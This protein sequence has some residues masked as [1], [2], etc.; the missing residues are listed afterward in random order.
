MSKLIS[1]TG[2]IFLA[3][4][5]LGFE[6]SD[7]SNLHPD[8]GEILSF[9]YTNFDAGLQ[10]MTASETVYFPFVNNSGHD[11]TI[12]DIVCNNKDYNSRPY[13]PLSGTIGVVIRNGQRDSIGFQRIYT[14]EMQEGLFDNSWTISFEGTE[15]KQYLNIFCEL[16]YT[17]GKLV[18]ESFV[19]PTVNRG[20]TIQFE[21]PIKNTGGT[22]AG[23]VDILSWTGKGIR[24]TDNL[25]VKIKPD[26]T[27]LVNFELY[28]D[29][30]YNDYTGS[31]G[32]DTDEEDYSWLNVE[33][34]GKLISKNHPSMK[35]D[36][37]ELS[38]FISQGDEAIFHFW[39]V[40]DGD[41]PLVISSAKTSC[42]CLVASYPRE[43]IRPG[44]RNEIKIRY[45]SSRVGP[46]N[47]SCSVLTNASVEPITLR[48]KGVITAKDTTGN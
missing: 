18:A 10:S 46:I 41:E 38:L 47:K 9:K 6:K 36:S 28:T 8:E 11:I 20:D 3:G 34:S 12:K 16:E 33:F 42:G 14:R 44:E 7:G 13:F 23:I 35:F 31:I 43:P 48:V 32:L 1:V 27:R 15:T 21:L 4:L 24:L 2:I 17:S 40:N 5:I 22:T 37:L 29:D 30:L 19:L 26:E 45:D 25:P 39:F